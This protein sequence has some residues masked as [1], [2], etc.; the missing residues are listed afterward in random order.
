MNLRAV[1]PCGV[2]SRPIMSVYRL[3]NGVTFGVDENS[4]IAIVVSGVKKL[5]QAEEE[6]AKG[7]KM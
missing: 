2:D 3:E 5:A 6:L 4:I 1:G 7:L